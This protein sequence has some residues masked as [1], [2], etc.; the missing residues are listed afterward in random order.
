MAKEIQKKLIINVLEHITNVT[1][2]GLR[3]SELESDLVLSFP[4]Q[5]SIKS[6][7]NKFLCQLPKAELIF[8]QDPKNNL[9]VSH[10][11]PNGHSAPAEEIVDTIQA[12]GV[13]EKVIFESVIEFLKKV[14]TGTT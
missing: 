6:Y 3:Y 8:S 11:F 12:D 1:N 2:V 13:N 4:V 5:R 9:R 10:K 7:T 14:K